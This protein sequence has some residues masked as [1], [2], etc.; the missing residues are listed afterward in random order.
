[1]SGCSFLRIDWVI[2]PC[3]MVILICGFFA[4]FLQ[5]V[6]CF[7]G[8]CM[9]IVYH[10]Q[11]GDKNQCEICLDIHVTFLSELNPFYGQPA[12]SPSGRI[13]PFVYFHAKFFFSTN[14]GHSVFSRHF[15]LLLTLD[16][17]LVILLLT[18]LHILEQLHLYIA[19][20]LQP[21]RLDRQIQSIGSNSS[22][23][24]FEG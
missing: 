11:A 4:F 24:E 9:T 19:S 20:E 21:C 1:M 12:M 2:T 3:R 13:E 18:H 23:G 10:A 6:S 5:V 22:V 7:G 16:S 8:R 14:F 17:N 15:S